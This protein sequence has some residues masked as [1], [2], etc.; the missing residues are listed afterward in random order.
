MSKSLDIKWTHLRKALEDYGQYFI[1]RAR[2]NLGRNG[3]YASG[4]LGDTMEYIVEIDDTHYSVQISIENYYEYVENGRK[5]GKFPP[6]DAIK[7]WVLIKPI[8][9]Q[10]GDARK[11]YDKKKPPTVEQLSFLIGRKIANEGIPPKPFFEPAK[12]ETEKHFETILQE[13]IKE[14]VDAYV[15]EHINEFLERFK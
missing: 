10:A 2:E 4:T 5:A 1:D 13:A 11:G 15:Q 8:R 7:N 3:S 14:D 6:P 9:P 12:E